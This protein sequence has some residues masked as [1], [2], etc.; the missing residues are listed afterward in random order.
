MFMMFSDLR[1][2]LLSELVNSAI[3]ISSLDYSFLNFSVFTSK[4][5]LLIGQNM[6]L[7]SSPTNWYLIR[8]IHL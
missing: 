8:L 4:F 3:Y 6:P 1:L 5:Q 7:I 2:D